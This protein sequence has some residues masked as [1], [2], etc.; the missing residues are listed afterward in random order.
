MS[1]RRFPFRQKAPVSPINFS[2]CVFC[3]FLRLFLPMSALPAI[4]LVAQRKDRSRN[5]REK[6]QKAQKKKVQRL[7]KAAQCFGLR[8]PLCHVSGP[9]SKRRFPSRAKSAGFT[10]KF[11][12]LRFLRL[13]AAIPSVLGVTGDPARG[14]KE[15]PKQKYPRKG[16]KSAKKEGAEI[17][18]GSSVIP[19]AKTTLSRY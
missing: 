19:V 8:R 12:F 4:P 13:F 9:M 10:D 7:Y 3:A 5:S 15:R 16:A 17:V 14:A 6:A 11:F 1:K 2:F 18:Q